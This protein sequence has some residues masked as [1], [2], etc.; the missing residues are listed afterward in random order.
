MIHFAISQPWYRLELKFL[1]I[2]L[3]RGVSVS[4]TDASY[5]FLLIR[6]RGHVCK[7]PK[8]IIIVIIV[9]IIIS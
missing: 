1:T 2:K 5:Y 8:V 9:I 3:L 7:Q 6:V 4:Y